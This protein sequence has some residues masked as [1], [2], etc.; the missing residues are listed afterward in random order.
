MTTQQARG[1]AAG[2]SGLGAGGDGEA[3]AH[4]S[5]LQHTATQCNT[6]QHTATHDGEGGSF[7]VSTQRSLSHG[8]EVG[9]GGDC[10]GATHC[11]TLQHT[12]RDS[13]R[14]RPVK[15][16]GRG[17]GGHLFQPAATHTDLQKAAGKRKSD[18]L[19]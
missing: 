7:Y 4:C 19:T 18:A 15:T 17:G 11:N 14:A 1:E 13:Q 6:L 8:G 10:E 3:A 9:A 2:A 16:E 12:A 5:T